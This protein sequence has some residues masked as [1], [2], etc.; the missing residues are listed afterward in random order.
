M[1]DKEALIEETDTFISGFNSAEQTAPVFLCIN[2]NEIIQETSEAYPD[3]DRFR[4]QSDILT[5]LYTLCTEI[6]P[7]SP[8]GENHILILLNKKQGIDASIIHHQLTITIR[9]HFCPEKP[10]F[11]LAYRIISYPE[12]GTSAEELYQAA[13]SE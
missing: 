6:G 12:N 13:L 3:I 4:L 8:A 9:Q 10:D 2:S 7:I 11:K 1:L 5:I